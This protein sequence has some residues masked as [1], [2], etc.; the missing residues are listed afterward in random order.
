MLCYNG[1]LVWWQSVFQ[2]P[3]SC[4][5]PLY[6]AVKM[7]MMILQPFFCIIHRCAC[8]DCLHF[9]F[10]SGTQHSN[11][12][13]SI[14]AP[15]IGS[16]LSDCLPNPF[17]KTW[18]NGWWTIFNWISARYFPSHSCAKW[19]VSTV[20][21]IHIGWLS[22]TVQLWSWELAMSVRRLGVWHMEG[23]WDS[24]LPH[25]YLFGSKDKE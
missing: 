14:Y 11:A 10:S 20:L 16:V 17:I 13:Q 5:A 4:Q 8:L 1:N 21:Q 9:H 2:H 24:I 25:L 23:L 19:P 7:I 12:D 3:S 15:N 22:K 6:I 18:L